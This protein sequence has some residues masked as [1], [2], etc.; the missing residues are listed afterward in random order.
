VSA[1]EERVTAQSVAR[2][3]SSIVAGLAVL[4]AAGYAFLTITAKMVTPAEYAALASLYLLI[5][6][7]GAG[8]FASV[9]LEISRLVSRGTAT[10]EPTGTAVRQLRLISAGLLVTVLVVLAAAAGP[11][12]TRVFDGDHWLVLG[13]AVAC[14]GYAVM[15][16][17]RGTFAGRSELRRYGATI[18]GEG[19]GR[20]LPCLGLALAGVHLASAYGIGLGLGPLLAAVACLPWVRL[21]ARGGHVP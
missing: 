14:A 8:L 1:V 4:G 7:F 9:D 2:G 19:L 21:G 5:V 12:S 16:L 13:L 15:S 10:G 17:P 11:L 6:V 3:A 20:L 18:G